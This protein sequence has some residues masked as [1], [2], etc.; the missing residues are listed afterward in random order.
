MKAI[1]EGVEAIFANYD[2]DGTGS[3]DKENCIKL[4]LEVIANVG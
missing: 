4:V 2:A 3:I 1:M